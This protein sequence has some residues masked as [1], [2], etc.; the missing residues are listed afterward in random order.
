VPDEASRDS[1]RLAAALRLVLRR[2]W[3]QVR[4]RPLVAGAALV[5]PGIGNLLIF[6]GPPLVVARLLAAVARDQ[7]LALADLWPYVATLAGLWLSGEVVWR[8]AGFTIARTEVRGMEA[9]YVEAMQELLAKDVAFFHDNFA[10]SLTKR[11][12]GYA[13]Q[14]ENVFDILSFAVTAN[15]IAL[16]LVTVVLWQYSP[17]LVAVLLTMI[18]ITLLLVL[19]RIRRRQ[20]LVHAREAASNVMAGHLAD[21]IANA[22]AVRAF[23]SEPDEAAVHARNVFDYGSKTLRTWDYQNL[24]I[25]TITAPMYVATNTLGLVVALATTRSSGAN[26]EAVFVTFSYYAAVT[27]VMWEFNRIYRTMEA[28]LT[29]A[30]QFAELL[31]DPPSV[32][33][34]PESQPFAPRDFGVELRDVSFGYTTSGPRLFEHLSLAIAPGTKVGF[35]GHSGGGKTT[36]TRLLLRFADLDG[37]AILIGG[38]P[39]DQVPQAALRR[40]I[41][42]VPQDP[43]MFHRSIADNIRF[44]RQNASDEDVR[45]AARLAHAAEFIEALPDGFD[46]LVGE[47]GIKL[48]GGQRQRVAIAR[49]ILKDAPILV[50]DEATSALDSESEAYIQDALWTLMEGRTAMV[51]A[52]RLSTVRRM[53]ELVVL[54]RGAVVERGTHGA[55][56]ARP[57]VYAALWA[58]QSGGFLGDGAGPPAG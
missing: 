22:E 45:R 36:L 21:S 37:G 52:H 2:Y 38:Q 35:V 33:D 41:A 31:L 1:T 17:L 18:A 23:A 16:S 48:S 29:D 43:S 8:L 5:L 19:P 30:A 26:L 3:A 6:Y 24:R 40:A 47:R 53:D 20:Q 14:F 44:G 27:R 25:D 15:L 39:I 32:V 55:L 49:A 51:I 54:E 9:L 58:R 56:L 34:A 4:R 28:A 7:T 12:L 46:T 10:G 13:R 50:L 57:G 42:Y 11:A